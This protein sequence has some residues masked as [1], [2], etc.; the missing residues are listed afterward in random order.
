MKYFI[1]NDLGCLY[2]L[3]SN[4]QL[5]FNSFM[6]TKHGNNYTTDDWGYVEPD[7]VG[8]ETV[9]F[10]GHDVTLYEVF[11]IVKGLLNG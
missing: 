11:K 6:T 4:G 5:M 3:D 7:L 2:K 10:N 8:E 9:S 1:C